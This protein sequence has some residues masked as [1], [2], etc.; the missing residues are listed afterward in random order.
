MSVAVMLKIWNH[1]NKFNFRTVICDEDEIFSLKKNRV[2]MD[3]KPELKKI[4][5]LL[6]KLV[7]VR[8]NMFT[9]GLKYKTILDMNLV[10]ILIVV[11]LFFF[12]NKELN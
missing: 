7:L 4:C 1:I 8:E 12:I 5:F 11:S 6:P 2:G 3:Y 9:N 10:Q